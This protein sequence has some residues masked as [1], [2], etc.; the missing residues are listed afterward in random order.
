MFNGIEPRQTDS[1]TSADRQQPV[2]E[3][4][5]DRG[6]TSDFRDVSVVSGERYRPSGQNETNQQRLGD[7]R[8]GRSSA[9]PVS[10]RSGSGSGR[11]VLW[12]PSPRPAVH[13]Q[14]QPLSETQCGGL[15]RHK[16]IDHILALIVCVVMD[17]G[18][19][20]QQFVSYSSATAHAIKGQLQKVRK[21]LKLGRSKLTTEERVESRRL[22]KNLRQDA[23]DARKAKLD[24]VHNCIQLFK[25]LKKLN[26]GKIT[27]H[28]VHFSGMELVG[29]KASLENIDMNLTGV[30]VVSSTSGTLVPRIRADVKATLVMPVPG[31]E[32]TRVTV[33]VTGAEL[34]LEGRAMPFLNSYLQGTSIKNLF[35]NIRR[36][37]KNR[38]AMFQLSHLGISAEKASIRLDQMEPETISRLAARSIYGKHRLIEQLM[39]DLKMPVDFHVGD[40][41]VYDG[42]RKQPMVEVGDLSGHVHCRRA[43]EVKDGEEETRECLLMTGPVHVDT[44]HASDLASQTIQKMTPVPMNLEPDAPPTASQPD[45]PTRQSRRLRLDLDQSELHFAM[46]CQHQKGVCKAKGTEQLNVWADQLQINNEGATVIEAGAGELYLS[47]HRKGS[48]R[49]VKAKAHDFIADVDM[50]ETLPGKAMKLDIHGRIQ[51]LGA[52]MSLIR[53][54]GN[55]DY[56]FQMQQVDVSTTSEPTVISKGDLEVTLPAKTMLSLDE[57]GLEQRKEDEQ[58]V[59]HVRVNQIKAGGQGDVQVRTP[60]KEWKI[61]VKG[62]AVVNDLELE[63][64]Q[65]T[66]GTQEVPETN[67]YAQAKAVQFSGL[68][69]AGMRIDEVVASLDEQGNGEIRLDNVALDGNELLKNKDLI[70]EEYRSWLSPALVQGR[71]FRCNIALRVHNGEIVSDQAKVTGLEIQHTDEASQTWSGWASGYLLSMLQ[72]LVNRLEVSDIN[73]CDGRM[74]LELNLKGWKL[75]VPLFNVSSSHVDGKGRVSVTSLMHQNTG[76]QLQDMRNSYRELL[77]KINAGQRG[78]LLMLEQTCQIVQ[79]Q[80]AVSILQRIDVNRIIAH[81]RRAGNEQARRD[82]AQLYRLFRQYPET[83]NRALLMTEFVTVSNDELAAYRKAPL[84]QQTDK[85]L[86]FQCLQR[87][88]E[89]KQAEEVMEQALLRSPD[90]PRLNYHAARLL[91]DLQETAAKAHLDEDQKRAEQARTVRL[92]S[93]ASRAG[94]SKAKEWLQER[95]QSGDQ[96]ATLAMCGE[97]LTTTR[98]VPDFFRVMAELEQLS[99]ASRREVSEGARR[100]MVNRAR[101]AGCM[102]LHPDPEQIKQLDAQNKLISAGRETELKPVDTYRW[103]LRFM[104]GIDGIGVNPEQARSLLQLSEEN[105]VAGAHLHRQVCD[106]LYPEGP[107]VVQ[108]VA[109]D[110]V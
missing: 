4:R 57:F 52:Q 40:L 20:R 30:D 67:T 13:P 93:K 99:A 63:I 16:F 41:Q 23:R 75:P 100:M 53:K 73:V 8:S 19:V 79:P 3:Q 56:D 92:L 9:R 94:H 62:K 96:Y 58:Q 34:T 98:D 42:D 50:K 39:A 82:A 105:G 106:T 110:A 68:D 77:D 5:S 35:S 85:V 86:L 15:L 33:D 7:R 48:D 45:S 6:R 81:A 76:V 29:G 90:N 95:A 12:Q 72:G 83:A 11:T 109:T 36:V 87:N 69:L 107:E 61:P 70:P 28:R 74:W 88:G 103:G 46:D 55:K 97:T 64:E 80:E 54:D 18:V 25:A 1:T 38:K 78:S 66:A 24:E 49:V 22:V 71:I 104:Y 60:A 14:T 2:T 47:V 102:F 91:V 108:N 37:R 84:E 59:K 44:E 10:V 32:P 43:D 17:M 101:N 89:L 65:Q 51:G 27:N 26:Q 31:K 21:L